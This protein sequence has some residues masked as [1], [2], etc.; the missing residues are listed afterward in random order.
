MT[1]NP[2]EPPTKCEWCGADYDPAIRPPEQP[3]ERRRAARTADP[4][5][6]THCEWCGAEYPTPEASQGA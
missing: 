5:P 2:V 1:S 4:E 6:V 3:P